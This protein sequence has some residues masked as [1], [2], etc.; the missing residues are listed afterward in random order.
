MQIGIVLVAIIIVAAAL[1]YMQSNPGGITIPTYGTSGTTSATSSQTTGLP[2]LAFTSPTNG[3]TL[4]G[5]SVTVTLQS[6]NFNT[7]SQG[8]YSVSLD[9]G[10]PQTGSGTSFTFSNLSPGPH[11]IRAALVNPDESQLNPAVEKTL[12]VNVP[13]A[14]SPVPE[15]TFTIHES[16]YKFDVTSITVNKGDK[17]TINAVV[18]GSIAHDICVEGYLD[19]SGN[20]LCTTAVSGGSTS[21]VTFIADKTGTFAYYCNIDGHRQLGMQGQLTVQ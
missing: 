9:G 6:S 11:I 21:S 1:Y 2:S 12:N 5:N 15:K 17:V 19:S 13:I 14:S 16:S 8:H 18:D 20:T 7:P 4:T 3:V 10:V